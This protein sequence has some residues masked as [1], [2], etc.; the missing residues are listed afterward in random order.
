MAR[1]KGI[2]K[3]SGTLGDINFYVIN[4]KAYARKAGGGFNGQAIKTKESMQRVRENGSEF[5]HCSRVKKEILGS[6]SPYFTKG[7][8]GFHSNCMSLFLKLKDFDNISKRGQRRMNLGLQSIEGKRLFKDFPFGKP[9]EILDALALK[10]KFKE[11]EQR[12][13]LPYFD[14]SGYRNLSIMTELKFSLFLVDFNFEAL[15]YQKHLL[16]ERSF[17]LQEVNPAQSLFPSSPVPVAHT[18][19]FYVGLEIGTGL[20]EKERQV[21]LRVV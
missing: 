14:G 1:Q 5:G 9:I 21:G 2:I 7:E 16:A 17:P 11:A 12:L 20:Q 18:P 10:W 8:R 19:I 6:F 3:L 4:G 13:D 15:E